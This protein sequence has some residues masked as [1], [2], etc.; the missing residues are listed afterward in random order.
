MC[1][2][3]G[4]DERG[5]RR[6]AGAVVRLAG[7]RPGGAGRV[8]RGRGGR[9]GGPA[10]P[11]GPAPARGRRAAP[12]AGA[13]LRRLPRAARGHRD[14]RPVRQDRLGR[15]GAAARVPVPDA[16]H[17]PGR[18]GGGPRRRRP[19]HQPG[20]AAAG[21]P[22]LACRALAGL[23]GLA[24]GA[25]ARGHGR[26]RP[27]DLVGRAG[28]VGVHRSGRHRGDHPPALLAARAR[29][30]RTGRSRD[31]H[32]AG[33]HPAPAA[34]PGPG[35]P[36]RAHRPVRAAA[37]G[38]EPAAAGSADRRGGPGRADRPGRRRVPDRPQAR[39]GGRRALPAWWWRTGPRASRPASR[40]G[41]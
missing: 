39:R 11:R 16:G 31:R 33:R 2:P 23:P 19:G 37:V 32:P 6:V 34:V 10:R 1:T 38:P 3:G 24:H 30:G 18:P 36:D 14:P 9:R 17:R 21:L 29:P 28:A 4:R 25:V 40:T 8:Q 26:Q 13:V 20:P 5:A 35:R 41:C 22:G 15:D 7:Q 12:D 27:A